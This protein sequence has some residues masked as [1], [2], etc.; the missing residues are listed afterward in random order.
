MTYSST[1]EKSGGPTMSSMRL[2]RWNKTWLERSHDCGLQIE[3]SVNVGREKPQRDEFS[4]RK[5]C[6][7]PD[8]DTFLC[9][10]YNLKEKS[11]RSPQHVAF[12]GLET[13]TNLKI[14]YRSQLCNT[15]AI[16]LFL[17]SSDGLGVTE[18]PRGEHQ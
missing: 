5:A 8:D 4:G 10:T 17:H 11:I 16:S 18:H 15:S 13:Q 3:A 7:Y 6:S 2:T 1:A 14:P 9:S 12:I